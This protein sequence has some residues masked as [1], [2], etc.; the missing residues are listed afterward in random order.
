M[1]LKE[2][3]ATTSAPPRRTR[4]IRVPTQEQIQ[5]QEQLQNSTFVIHHSTLK[6]C[7]TARQTV[8]IN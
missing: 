7:L 4:V 2:K 3:S 8:G 5:E 1:W 6:R